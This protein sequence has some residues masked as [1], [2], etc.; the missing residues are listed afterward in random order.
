MFTQANSLVWN[1]FTLFKNYYYQNLFNTLVNFK[2]AFLIKDD[3]AAETICE[4][5][6][7]LIDAYR[8]DI[9]K[10]DTNFGLLDQFDLDLYE[11][12]LDI[13]SKYNILVPYMKS[14]STLTEIQ[15]KLLGFV[16]G[17]H[18]KF[19]E[20]LNDHFRLLLI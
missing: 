10:S 17:F 6:G 8:L 9:S 11:E 3:Y 14:P 5:L 15:N 1:N 4:E 12:C 20:T 7:G 19:I 16:Q 18:E 13:K 2:K